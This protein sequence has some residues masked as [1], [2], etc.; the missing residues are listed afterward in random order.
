MAGRN[1]RGQAAVTG[2]QSGACAQVV[3][4]ESR[5]FAGCEVR[6]RGFQ[7]AGVDST[8]DPPNM[9]QLCPVLHAG[10][11]LFDRLLLSFHGGRHRR[12]IAR[13]P[14]LPLD[15]VRKRGVLSQ[16][17]LGVLAPLAQA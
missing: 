17:G 16:V 3:R 9:N 11:S 15:L 10:R 8:T 2:S 1:A 12:Q 5:S 4:D 7:P 13:L 14:Y 6:S